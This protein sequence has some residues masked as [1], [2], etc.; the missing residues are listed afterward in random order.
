MKLGDLA[1]YGGIVIQCHD[2]PDADAIASG[3]ALLRFLESRGADARLVYSGAGRV[4]KTNLTWMLKLL[5]I[6]L[7]YVD[8][9]SECGLLVTV[10]CQYGAGNVRKFGAGEFAVLDHHRPEIPEGPMVVIQPALGSCSTLVW[11]L[12]RSEGFDF[13]ANPEV[14]TALYYGLFTDT[15]SL[16]EMRHPLDRDLSEFMPVDWP[17][18]KKLKNSMLSMDELDVVA[19]TLSSAR[20]IENM[21]LLKSRPCDPN[22]LGFSSDI[23]QQVEQFGSCVVYCDVPTGLKLSI[24]SVAREIMANELAAFLTKGVG[25]GGGGIEKAGGYISGESLAKAF[26]GVTPDDF[27]RSR[28]ESYQNNFDLVYCD[29]HKI[30]FASMKRFRKLPIPVGCARTTDMFSEGAQINVRTLE[31]DVDTVASWDVYVMIGPQGEAYPIRKDRYEESYADCD[32]PYAPRFEY[33][34]TITEKITGEKKSVL[35]FARPCVAKGDKII[36]AS[37]LLKD[38]KVFSKWDS[39]KY[40]HGSAGDYIAA[41]ETDFSDVYIINRDIFEKTYRAAD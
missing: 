9:L 37:K 5:D 24:R 39:E 29:D 1:R 8:E 16:A 11:S 2:I 25:S 33:E 32:A 34:P 30:D 26:P 41:P 38:T 40:F 15:N 36:R 27:L 18:I 35:P 6:P 10:D 23:A 17:V 7:E 3:F 12:M 21:G 22:L 19:E 20:I 4:T 13:A 28:V 31:G 14:F